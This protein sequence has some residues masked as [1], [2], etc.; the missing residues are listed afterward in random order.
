[1]L[2]SNEFLTIPTLKHVSLETDDVRKFAVNWATLTAISLRGKSFRT[3]HSKSEVAKILQQTKCLVSCDI[4]VW[5]RSKEQTDLDK[6][7]LPFLET[8]RINES[9]IRLAPAT[10]PEAPSL[11]DHLIAPKLSE[12]NILGKFLELSL[13]NFLERSPNILKLDL[14]Y[15]IADKSLTITT[16]LLRHCKSLT[17]V[18][19]YPSDYDPSRNPSN[20]DANTFLRGFVE[21]EGDTSVICPRLQDFKLTGGINFSPETLR[22]FLEGKQRSFA[23]LNIAPLRIAP[24]RTVII[25]IQAINETVTQLEILELISQKN[26]EGLDVNALLKQED[27]SSD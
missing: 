3:S 19:L 18:S 9:H 22:L 5:A 1:M 23:A 24:W 6:I 14:P 13:I 7:S 10:S 16:T 17:S 25:D 11:L 26:S 20:W 2:S 8:L 4:V 12:L 21:V 27:H 15:L